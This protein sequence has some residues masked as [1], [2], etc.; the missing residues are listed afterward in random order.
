MALNFETNRTI[1]SYFRANG[2]NT[3]GGDLFFYLGNSV[4][5]Q[6]YYFDSAATISVAWQSMTLELTAQ[7]NDWVWMGVGAEPDDGFA[8]ANLLTDATEFG[9]ALVGVTVKPP[10]GA[11]EP[12]GTLYMDDFS[13]TPTPAA[14][15]LFPIALG[16]VLWARRKRRLQELLADGGDATPTPG[17]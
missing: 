4:T 5:G 13:A 17:M 6:Y 1:T 8:R 2:L 3:G 11:P 14:A 16:A 12:R 7:Q 10:P 9:W 15:V